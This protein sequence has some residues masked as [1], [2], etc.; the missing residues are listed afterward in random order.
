MRHITKPMILNHLH[1]VKKTP[2]VLFPPDPLIIVYKQLPYP[3]P[4]LL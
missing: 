2:I 4:I 1:Q 3:A